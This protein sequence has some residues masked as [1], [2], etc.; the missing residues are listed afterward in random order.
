MISFD[1][2][3]PVSPLEIPG[4][5]VVE[6]PDHPLIARVYALPVSAPGSRRPKLAFDYLSPSQS[7]SYKR[8]SA[9]YLFKYFYKLREPE[10]SAMFF[11]SAVHAGAEAYLATKRAMTIAGTP[12]SHDGL[13]Q[14][15]LDA[16]ALYV[17]TRMTDDMIFKQQWKNG[18]TETAESLLESTKIATASLADEVWIGIDALETERG[19]LIVWKDE[20][21]L[22]FLGYPDVIEADAAGPIVRDLKTGTEKKPMDARLDVALSCYAQAYEI[23]SGVPTRR[24]GYHSYVR[25][26]TPKIVLVESIR[27]DGDLSRLFN[28]CRTLTKALALGIY[29]PADDAME[30]GTCAFFQRCRSEFA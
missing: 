14:L 1:T 7:K 11:G 27:E 5:T 28:I 15:A 21:V 24:V 10:N 26:K 3:A 19:F 22:P 20:R 23:F 30:C 6:S 8:C 16:T 13:K 25:N 4:A 9:A 29:L 18:P 12:A 17:R 2:Q